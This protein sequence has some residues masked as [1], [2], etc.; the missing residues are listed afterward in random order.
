MKDLTDRQKEVLA[1]IS[2]F[3]EEHSYP[4]TIREIAE[5]FGIS[6]KGA[7]D[8]VKALERKKTLRLG[9]NR[10]RSIEVLSRERPGAR[11]AEV[12]LLGT[13]AAGRPILSEENL[14]GT[15]R[16]PAEMLRSR[17]GFALRVRGDSMRDAGILD[18]DLAVIEER[19][20]A[21]N[22]EIVV[23]MIDDAVTLKRFHRETGRIRL[24]AEN[25]SYAPIYTQDA[26]ILGRLRGI[27]RTY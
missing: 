8:H 24:S 1:Y 13:V 10:S 17:P 12:P 16:I 20:M 3:S 22:G 6:V 11:Y 21:E 7:Y 18:G 27:L 19:P 9:E 26:R 5:R 23:A 2:S 14:D 25:P 15:I 4:P